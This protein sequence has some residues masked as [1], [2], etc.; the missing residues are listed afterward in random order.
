MIKA[1][2]VRL[3]TMREALSN[4]RYFGTMLSGKSWAAWR[5]LLIAIVGEELTEDDRVIFR[6]LKGRQNEPLRPVDEFWAV[7]GRRGGKTRAMAVLSA[8]LAACI[9]YRDLLAPSERAKLP[10]IAAS[11]EQAATAFAF[12]RGAFA[13][14]PILRDLVIDATAGVIRLTTKIDIE[15]RSASFRT[16]RSITSVAAVCDEIAFWRSDESANPDTEILKALRPTLA[17]TGG[18]LIAIGSPHA[19]RG[20]LYQR[21]QRHYGADG[22]ARILV[23]KAPT[24]LMNP[25][26]PQ[27][28]IDRAYEE[29]PEGASAEYGAEFPGDIEVFVSREALDDCVEKGV[30]ARAPLAGVHYQAFCD[31]SGG[32]NDSMTLAIAHGENGQAILDCVVERKAPFS[33]DDVCRE[34]AATLKSYRTTTVTGDRYA[35]E[36]PRERFAAHGIDYQPAEMNRSALYL[37]FLPLVNAR[38]AALL[39]NERLIVQFAQLERHTS[40]GGRDTVDHIRGAHDDMANAVAGALSAIADLDQAPMKISPIA[41]AEVRHRARMADAVRVSGADPTRL[42]CNTYFGRRTNPRLAAGSSRNDY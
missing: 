24:H 32:S 20:E 14:S 31:P 7:V 34:F 12:T 11:K 2:P 9:D 25:S 3:V 4:P 15:I 42:H 36:W 23:A 5:V 27:S 29:D 26:L 33:P 41:L 38:R 19:K 28:V 22:N 37:S 30:H 1:P 6:E 17:T 18:P 39:D 8:Y 10:L 35:G 16:I 21:F 40:R 13:A